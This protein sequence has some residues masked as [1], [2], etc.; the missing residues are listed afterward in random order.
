[1]S[2]REYSDTLA[3]GVESLMHRQAAEISA[4]KQIAHNLAQ[5]LELN[6][7]GGIASLQQQMDAHDVK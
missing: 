3:I 6:G 4:W 2:G 5:A 7:L 1:M